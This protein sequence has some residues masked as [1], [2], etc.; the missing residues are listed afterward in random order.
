MSERYCDVW[1]GL[2]EV[3]PLPGSTILEGAPGA[4]SNVLAL[5]ENEVE[6]KEKVVGAL[7]VLG[8]KVERFE[9]VEPLR[10]DGVSVSEDLLE[11]SY[12][13]SKD[14]TVVYDTFYIFEQE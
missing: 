14:R 4:Y 11:L 6:Y 1:K 5:A 3:T 13:L 8:L 7:R 2:V 12:E 10:R 9:D